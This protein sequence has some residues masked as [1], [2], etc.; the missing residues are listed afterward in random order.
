MH[1]PE[2]LDMRETAHGHGANGM[3]F[4]GYEDAAGLG[5]QMQARRENGRSRFVE[6]W[7]HVALPER[8][9]A[10]LVELRAAVATLTDE[11]IAAEAAKYPH[12]RSI[13]TDTCGNA[14]RL[15]PRRPYKPGPRI[16]HDTTRVSIAKCWRVATDSSCSLCADHLK[17][18]EGKPAELVAALEAEVAER[19]ARAA[20]RG[21]SW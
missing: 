7:F 13:K 9:F 2:D 8:A 19:K 16:K 4:Y 20:A 10:S 21:G 3:A 12:F 11:Q 1:I 15:C 18:F 6:T 17:Q 14:C 5:V